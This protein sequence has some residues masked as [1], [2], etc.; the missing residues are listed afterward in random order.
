[1]SC[2]R[3]APSAPQ[4]RYVNAG[5]KIAAIE[6]PVEAGD[7][8]RKL[9]QRPS[10]F[11][12]QLKRLEDD[13]GVVRVG[14]NVASLLHR[15]MSRL[16]TERGRGEL[17]LSWRINTNF[18]PA[19]AIPMKKFVLKSNKTDIEHTQPPHFKTPLRKE[20]L[21]SLEW[22]LKQESSQAEPFIEE[23]V[24]EAILAPL[25]WR[26]E[27]RA[28][29]DVHVK[30]GVLADQVGY[31]KTAISLGLIDCTH[32]AVKEEFEKA[33]T[34][35]G[36]IN[37]HATLVVVPPHLTRQWDS[38]VT[39]FTRKNRFKTLVLSSVTNLNSA[40][41][42]DFQEADIIIVASNIFKSA[43]YLE[44]LTNFA[45][46]AA[47]PNKEGRHFNAHLKTVCASLKAQVDR[48]RD[49][50][51]DVVRSNIAEAQKRGI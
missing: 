17:Q 20:Q 29:R 1:M 2:E 13:T 32:D 46:T 48:L 3:C 51:A 31:G 47:L 12:T 24:A 21:R 15:A 45:G 42:E 19:A 25:G 39:K 50:G 22:M 6:D 28:Q 37:I 30:G 38:E 16:P 4:V 18:T 26:A 9:K 33:D 7:Y 36:K 43:T 5:K 40:T 35:P 14:L 10:P 34:I 49:E 44:N 41:I 27:G 11:I 8:E 23:E